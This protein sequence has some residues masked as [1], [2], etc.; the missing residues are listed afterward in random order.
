MLA[1]RCLFGRPLPIQ[2][3]VAEKEID[4]IQDG[5][6]IRRKKSIDQHGPITMLDIC[7]LPDPLVSHWSLPLMTISTLVYSSVF[8]HGEKSTSYLNI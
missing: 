2:S 8:L 5:S 4:F 3:A 1:A 6:K 7:H